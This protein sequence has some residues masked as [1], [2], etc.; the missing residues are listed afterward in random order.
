[1][2]GTPYLILVGLPG[3]GKSSVGRGVAERLGCPFV[4]FDVEIERRVGASVAQIFRERGEPYFREQE[5]E[6]TRELAR[7]W[8]EGPEGEVG[9]QR[10]MVLAPGGGWVTVPGALEL[11][12]PP[13]RMIYLRVHPEVALRRMGGERVSRPLLEAADPV[14]ALERL[15]AAREVWYLAADYVVD[16]DLVD[17]Q[18]VISI[19]TRLAWGWGGG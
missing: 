3:S 14:A 4:D 7:A 9:A 6:L 17:L 18:G 8:R 12:R 11:L 13:A 10:G 5:L 1:M 2:G 16:V 15:L 19:V